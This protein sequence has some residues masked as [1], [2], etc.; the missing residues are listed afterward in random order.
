[1]IYADCSCSRSLFSHL[2]K[3]GP[4]A[5]AEELILYAGRESNQHQAAQHSGFA[6]NNI[7]DSELVSH[8]GIDAA[9]VLIVFDSK[10][11]LRYAGGYYDHPATINPLDER[12]HAQLAAGVHVQPL[13]LFGC[14][15]DAR[16]KRSLDPFRFFSSR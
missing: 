5:G 1:V 7:S 11:K 9:P 2:L 3:R 15:V 4:F 8:F 16:L 12:I 13:P 10:G 14:A 6:F